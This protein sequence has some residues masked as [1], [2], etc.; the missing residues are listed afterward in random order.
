MTK[1]TNKQALTYVL[2]NCDLPSEVAERITAQLASL[3]RKASQS[4]TRPNAK[5]VA[6]DALREKIVE[7]FRANVDKFFRCDDIAAAIPEL[8][9]KHNQSISALLTPLKRCEK[10]P[11]GV[12]IRKETKGVAYF[13][14]PSTYEEVGE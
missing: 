8:N 7:F 5:Q 3:E 1:M 6:N 10:I 14:I 4:A 2:E 12:V 11:D 13:G 9:G